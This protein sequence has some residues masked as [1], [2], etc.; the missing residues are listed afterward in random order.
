[1]KDWKELKKELLKDPK[2][3]KL[4]E[5]SEPEYQIARAIIR[6]RIE[7]GYTQKDLAKKLNT[8]QSVVSRL[9]NAGSSPSISLLK[10]LAEALD[11]SLQVQFKNL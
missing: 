6:A 9:E 4:Y 10:R 8:T 3:K 11:T 5:D 7:K 1:M 2:F